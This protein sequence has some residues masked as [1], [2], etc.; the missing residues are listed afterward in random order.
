MTDKS[1]PTNQSLLTFP[2]DFTIKVFGI[3][4]EE[5][6]ATVL[7]IV[8]KHVPNLSDRAI[9]SRPSEHGKYC[10]LTITVHVESKEQLD[11]IYQDLSANKQ[12]LMAL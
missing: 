4:S 2:C 10:A 7:T 11:Q 8:H 6:E 1:N 9:Q 5:F 12:I 3:A